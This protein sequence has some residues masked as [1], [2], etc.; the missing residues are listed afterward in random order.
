MLPSVVLDR[1]PTKG[2]AIHMLPELLINL[3]V[4]LLIALAVAGRGFRIDEEY[5]AKWA[6]SAGLELTAESRPVVRRYLEW[7]RRS[8]T[9]GGL[10]G[11]LAPGV[12]SEVV[13][14][15]PLRDGGWSFGLM[16]V[17]YVL[18]VLLAEVVTNRRARRLGSP[19][20]VSR[21]LDD[22]LPASV[23]TLQRGLGPLSAALVVVYALLEPHAGVSMPDVM[24]VAAVG[25]A[26]ACFALVIEVLQRGIIARRWASAAGDVPVEDAVRSSSVHVLAGAG[27]ALLLNVAGPMAILSLLTVVGSGNVAALI[28]FP[29][30]LAVFVTSLLLWSHLV[31][32][33]GFRVRRGDQ[34]VHA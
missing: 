19:A 3:A 1:T 13:T 20:L 7:S 17:G 4:P 24:V 16:L 33:Q 10:I 26:G 30:F 22:Y 14:G 32:P 31:Q 28:G 15:Q 2:E 34:A 25:V 27:I 8:R 23:V 6:S 12:Y 9:A 11:F 5:V 21:R 29:L 18:G